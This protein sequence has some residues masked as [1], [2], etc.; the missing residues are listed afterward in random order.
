MDVLNQ[1]QVAAIVRVRARVRIRVRVRTGLCD[2]EGPSEDLGLGHDQLGLGQRSRHF[3]VR[4][5][6]SRVNG[7]TAKV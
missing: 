1:E 2:G 4:S 5:G 7:D 3:L 6:I